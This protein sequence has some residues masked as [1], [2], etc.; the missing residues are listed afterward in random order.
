MHQALR[1]K[2]KQ[3]ERD[4]AVMLQGMETVDNRCRTT[5]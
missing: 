1:L 4:S 5:C 3:D 2:T